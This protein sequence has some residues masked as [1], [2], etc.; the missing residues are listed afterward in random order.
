MRKQK[1]FDLY[2]TNLYKSNIRQSEYDG[3]ISDYFNNYIEEIHDYWIDIPKRQIRIQGL[4]TS[5]ES[6]N[7][8]EPGV[9]YNMANRVN[10]NLHIL[11]NISETEPVTI[12]LHTNG[13]FVHE[14]MSI[15]DTI[16]A[17]PYPV[18]IIN[19]VYARSM[20]GFIL[21]AGDTRLMLP[22][23]YFMFHRGTVGYSGD[24][25]LVDSLKKHDDVVEVR[26][27]K[28]FT[29]TLKKK[30]KFRHKSVSW[31]EKMLEKKMDE[32]I[33]VFLTAEEAVE[34]GFADRIIHS[35]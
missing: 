4:E 10:K 14:G 9:E 27:M 5:P 3:N 29:D 1:R 15:F 23:S 8:E 28:I 7:E 12:F 13:G 26:L 33:D 21:L 31:I 22:N 24:P 35:F 34:W 19:E 30:G 25:K 32:K 17:M 18:T 6:N 20:S 2:G 11:K 16:K